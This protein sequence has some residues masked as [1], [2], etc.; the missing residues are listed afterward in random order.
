MS[1]AADLTFDAIT[2]EY[3]AEHRVVVRFVEQGG[4]HRPPTAVIQ[5]LFG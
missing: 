1:S 3:L 5:R 4:K 2:A